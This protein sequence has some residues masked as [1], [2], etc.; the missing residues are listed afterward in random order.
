MDT[1]IKNLGEALIYIDEIERE[2]DKKEDEI[3]LLKAK[4]ESLEM[5]LENLGY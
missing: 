5:A 4:I 3:L 2:L 1:K